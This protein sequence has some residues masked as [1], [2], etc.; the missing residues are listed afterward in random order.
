M[1]NI[2]ESKSLLHPVAEDSI[3]ESHKLNPEAADTI[4]IKSILQHGDKLTIRDEPMLRS[5]FNELSGVYFHGTQYYDLKNVHFINNTGIANLIDLLKSLL[6][7]NVEVRF[8][9]VSQ[10]VKEKIRS[11]GLE[12]ILNC[13]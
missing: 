6:Q 1:E 9:N 5:E 13:C 11:M 3:F 12:G 10:P 4:N 8:V 7:Q 2:S